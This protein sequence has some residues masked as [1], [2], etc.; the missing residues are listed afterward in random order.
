MKANEEI[1]ALE[2][3]GIPAVQ[4]LVL[5]RLLAL[6]TIQVECVFLRPISPHQHLSRKDLAAQ[7]HAMISAAYHERPMGRN[8]AERTGFNADLR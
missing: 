8:R 7:A 2:T 4:F 1:D 3:L 5:P 6:R